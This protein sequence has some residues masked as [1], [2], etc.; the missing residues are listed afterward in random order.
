VENEIITDTAST[1]EKANS[2]GKGRILVMDDDKM[3][4]QVL[5]EM[6]KYI[7][8]EVVCACDGE[9]SIELYQEAKMMNK[10][11]DVVIMDLTIPGGLG[12][13][14]TIKEL[15]KIDANVKA[16]VSSGYSNDPVMAHYDKYGFKGLVAKPF[17][18][19]EIAQVLIEVI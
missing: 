1:A 17:S 3:L 13:K 11:F 7:G 16:I 8:Y 14:E 6:L 12:G 19:E 10:P 9:K 2:T 15:L 4:R 18:I 5:S